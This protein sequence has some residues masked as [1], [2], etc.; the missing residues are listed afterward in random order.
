[1]K[2]YKD[3][4]YNRK[5]YIHWYMTYSRMEKKMNKGLGEMSFKEWSKIVSKLMEFTLENVNNSTK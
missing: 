5:V 4:K 1:M 3:Y 2:T